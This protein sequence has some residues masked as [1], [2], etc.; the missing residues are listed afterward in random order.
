MQLLRIFPTAGF[1]QRAAWKPGPFFSKQSPVPI[2]HFPRRR[3]LHGLLRMDPWRRMP[4]W[5]GFKISFQR[6]P[7]SDAVGV[8]GSPAAALFTEPGT[9]VATNSSPLYGGRNSDNQFFI[10][11]RDDSRKHRLLP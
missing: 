6:R 1:M 4:T 5:S 2:F 10:P 7:G 11:E 3:Q 9:W 8:Y